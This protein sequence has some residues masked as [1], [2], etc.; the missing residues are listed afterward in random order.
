M[1]CEITKIV[2]ENGEESKLF[3]A[4]SEVMSPE[5][6]L[7]N[8]LE[9]RTNK[10]YFTKLYGE[11]AQGE[12][13]AKRF[14]E[15]PKFKEINFRDTT[16]AEDVY[17]TI[18]DEMLET[19]RNMFQ[20]TSNY[21]LSNINLKALSEDPLHLKRVITKTQD[22]LR[23]KASETTSETAKELLLV[24]AK[25]LPYFVGENKELGPVGER[26]KEF[27]INI[28]VG[29][30]Y[31]EEEMVY[32]EVE[33][34]NDIVD[35]D[36]VEAEH[37]RIY[38]MHILASSPANSLLGSLKLY[39]RGLK[40]IDTTKKEL[41]YEVSDTNYLRPAEE[42]IILSEL[43]KALVGVQDISEII[44]RLQKSVESNKALHQ[45][46]Q[47][48]LSEKPVNI[49][50]IGV[51][52]P[53]TVALFSAAKQDYD[54][55]N[56]VEDINNAVYL[57]DSNDSTTKI[58]VKKQWEEN[59]KVLK[60]KDLNYKPLTDKL[61]SFLSN[62]NT[63]AE[64]NKVNSSR[65][66]GN[67]TA[68]PNPDRATLKQASYFFR[69]AGM[70]EVTTDVLEEAVFRVLNNKSLLY[71]KNTYASAFTVID[72]LLTHIPKKVFSEKVSIFSKG[73]IGE[74]KAINLLGSIV[75]DFSGNQT[76][77]AFQGGKGVMM[78]PL[79]VGS[80]AQDL[81]S[82]LTAGD[83]VSEDL[84]NRYKQD[85][86][87]KNTTLI[88]D[89]FGVRDGEHLANFRMQALDTLKNNATG[90]GVDYGELSTFDALNA[91]IN[92]FFSP[93]SR[94]TNYFQAFTPTQG[95][96]GNLKLLTVPIFNLRDNATKG[97]IKDTLF[98]KN[99][100]L[101]S[102]EVQDWLIDQV[103]AEIIR[104]VNASRFK[105]IKNYGDKGGNAYK[106]NL[107]PELN[108]ELETIREELD[109]DNAR[110]YAEKL[111][112]KTEE[113]FY[114]A[115]QEDKQ[116]YIDNGVF[117]RTNDG[118]KVTRN[119][120]NALSEY[121]TNNANVLSDGRM[122]TFLA[123]NF[124]YAY[125]QMLL[126]AGDP[127]FFKSASE[128]AQKTD[129]NKRFALPF[130]PGV[131]PAVGEFSG[132]PRTYNVKIAEEGLHTSELVDVL[133]GITG[134]K[135]F[136][137]TQLADGW[138]IVSL[139][140]Y[141]QLLV[142]R[143][144]HND[145]LLQLI[146]DL[147]KWKPGTKM[148]QSA[149][150]LSALKLFYFEVNNFGTDIMTP[151]S[152]KYSVFPAI[153]T[154]FKQLGVDGKPKFPAL[155]KIA[156]ELESTKP[157]SADEIVMPSAVKVG[158][159]ERTNVDDLEKAKA[160]TLNNASVRIPQPES[161]KIKVEDILGS[162]VRKHIIG[163]YLENLPIH[164]KNS[165][166]DP[167]KALDTYNKAISTVVNNG[168]TNSIDHFLLN[169][170][171]DE[172]YLINQILEEAS[173]SATQSYMMFKNALGTKGEEDSSI[174][175]YTYP[176]LRYKVENMINSYFRKQVN[177][178]KVPGHSAVQ[179][180]SYG[181]AKRSDNTLGVSSDLKFST[182]VNE[183]GSKILNQDT[184]IS[185]VKA[186]KRGNPEDLEL[187]SQYKTS[188][189]EVRV[190][191]NF[192]IGRLKQIA[193][194]KVALHS[195]E[196][197]EEAKK[198]AKRNDPAD[199][200]KNYTVRLAQ[201][202]NKM[203]KTTF[204][205]M[206]RNVTDGNGNLDAEK[207]REQ[208]LDEVVLYRI[209]T[210]GKNS[211]LVGR[212]KEFLPPHSGNTIQVPSEVVDQAG[213]DFDI[214]K[215]WIEMANFTEKDGKLYKDTY[216]SG[217]E[218]TVKQAQAAILDFHK[219]VL[220]SPQYIAQLLE[221]NT[222]SLLEGMVKE[223]N[224]GEEGAVGNLASVQLQ[225]TFRDNNKSGKDLISI[226][227][228]SA[229]NHVTAQHIGL[230]M[231]SK[232]SLNKIATEE[233]SEKVKFGQLKSKEGNFIS[234]E[235]SEVQ[236]AALDNANNPILGNLNISEFT[237]G[238]LNVVVSTGNGLSLGVKLL[239][240]PI[241][242]DLAKLYPKYVRNMSPGRALRAAERE[243]RSKYNLGKLKTGATLNLSDVNLQKAELLLDPKSA[244]DHQESLIIFKSLHTIGED[245]AKYQRTMNIDS[246]GVPSTISKL[247][248]I[249]EDMANIS[250][251]TINQIER[252]NGNTSDETDILGHKYPKLLKSIEKRGITPNKIKFKVDPTKWA[253]SHLS[254]MVLGSLYYPLA[255]HKLISPS[256]SVQ[257]Q[258]IL[259]TA[260]E[261]FGSI[262]DNMAVTLLADYD[263]F[264]ATNS[265]ATQ[266]EVSP[267]AKDIEEGKFMHLNNPV[268]PKST[269]KLVEAYKS[270]KLQVGEKVNGFI[271]K[272]STHEDQGKSF[273]TFLNMNTKAL[274]N[275]AKDK[276]LLEFEE[277]M[278]SEDP[279]ENALAESVALYGIVN[280]G[281]AQSKNS[282][283]HLL[284][285]LAHTVYTTKDG[286]SLAGYFRTVHDFVNTSEAFTHQ[287]EDFIDKYV[288]NNSHRLKLRTERMNAYTTGLGEKDYW[289]DVEM[290]D[291][292]SR[293]N[294]T[295]PAYVKEIYNS[296]KFN[297]YKWKQT[298]D[299]FAG[300]VLLDKWGIP[301]L[302]TE[303][304]NGTSHYNTTSKSTDNAVEV[305]KNNA[306]VENKKVLANYEKVGKELLEEKRISYGEYLRSI[307][308][309]DTV[310]NSRKDVDE[311]VDRAL[312]KLL[313][314]GAP[315]NRAVEFSSR[316]DALG[317]GAE[318]NIAKYPNNDFNTVFRERIESGFTEEGSQ[319]L[320]NFIMDKICS[321]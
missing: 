98:D 171:L 309:L 115:L 274:S 308:Y 46:L 257:Y 199:Y 170:T 215:V 76:L 114:K 89:V 205:N 18:I 37:Q 141:K 84:L 315:K 29:S 72:T 133:Q 319:G 100:K 125:E 93:N 299:G 143:G 218:L 25:N 297:I 208:N 197:K 312:D 237:A 43:Y 42:G 243:V 262:D 318:K 48:V 287:A 172:P 186:A 10:K 138:G 57:A 15:T 105:G 83:R 158:Q 107:F 149:E 213:S 12:I 206:W 63:K 108:I 311:M 292:E 281:F 261:K 16:Q 117:T 135:K 279:T 247:Y 49:P 298:N 165:K 272:L 153:P 132:L 303:Y 321:A 2:L 11:N 180:S 236:N 187:L 235:L 113:L 184:I 291:F 164:M 234:R 289:M 176:T 249:Y 179:I 273:V 23:E 204:D 275:K 290:R 65:V 304:H 123:N 209:P 94:K 140:R 112:F 254:D 200:K 30:T 162:Q 147:E 22:R 82:N 188:A 126:F 80:Q 198:F 178:F 166:V 17:D 307:G 255:T 265:R 24:A 118:L 280:Y 21:T 288:A 55:V 167:I 51:Y 294:Y 212:I 78:H 122:D 121:V 211:M 116:F 217:E 119:S 276:L 268:S 145:A 286:K 27:G 66:K 1:A 34:I 190:T 39:L 111:L 134:T 203:Q 120:E 232:F 196:L 79:N 251:T 155:N 282:F 306:S 252:G 54:L 222:T 35:T 131:K 174:L 258:E 157:T 86:M 173:K 71:S 97:E 74:T 320:F 41:Q 136:E 70:P 313:D 31:I 52:K 110:D 36:Q 168:I 146:D 266:I 277:L 33:D 156:L 160:I 69:D 45:V 47:N 195:K 267:L 202:T 189:A 271:K 20:T 50:G 220:S 87:Y 214:D 210:Q 207:L 161:T 109:E 124:I 129:I 142:A 216:N 175:P 193:E 6:A 278:Y 183:D 185:L 293:K 81:I 59:I 104:I 8:Y 75:N 248:D 250:G 95:D 28:A 285:P 92:A 40:K 96:K 102:R 296:G 148:P 163:N 239:N 256:A 128:S 85:P 310:F 99:G 77:G 302:I 192:F 269:A 223:F 201:Q 32:D 53:L 44:P 230:E 253:N 284:P 19:M 130:T 62:R 103:E 238:A 60:N 101:Q 61:N 191:P 260:K 4:L 231:L 181:T 152:L 226:A 295:P 139:K 9:F 263:T 73:Q 56:I 90:I 150:S 270:K 67:T 127:A 305:G 301:G 151:F 244:S 58:A 177:R 68:K 154:L 229:V 246:K 242:K 3:Q 233:G 264:L 182:F 300:Y 13:N 5:L 169:N 240:A 314:L 316:L 245:L 14:L 227:S 38:D 219:G 64:L 194:E 91:R 159:R 241:I 88:R 144:I 7:E 221:P 137:E 225:E 224:T 259:T 283:V 106:F 26:L 228:V 317:R